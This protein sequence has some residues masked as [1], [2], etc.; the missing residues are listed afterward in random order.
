MMPQQ[1]AVKYLL[2]LLLASN[3]SRLGRLP[4][5]RLNITHQVFCLPIIW[6][7]P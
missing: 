3:D 2:L 5:S 7:L 4:G 1:W 6:S